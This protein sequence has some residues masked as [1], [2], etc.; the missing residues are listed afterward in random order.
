MFT[1]SILTE[2]CCMLFERGRLLHDVI[3]SSMYSDVKDREGRIRKAI[4]FSWRVF[5][6]LTEGC[7]DK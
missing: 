2:R 1:V 6:G 3:T 5:Q 4:V 7:I